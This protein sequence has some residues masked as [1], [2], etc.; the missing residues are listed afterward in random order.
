MIQQ[1]ALTQK[2]PQCL[3]CATI[4]PDHSTPSIAYFCMEYCVSPDL[5]VYSGGLGVLAGDQLKAANDLG[6]PLVGVG[7]FYHHGYFRQ[8]IGE[9]GWQIEEYPI[10]NPEAANLQILTDQEGQSVS[11]EV[12]IEDRTVKTQAYLKQIGTIPLIL[13]TT[14]IEENSSE[15]RMITAHLYGAKDEHD[16][17]TRIR[18]EMILGI[19]GK[20]MLDKLG[21]KVGVYHMNEG[22]SAFLTIAR[23]EELTE[24]DI[25]ADQA[26]EKIQANQ[27]FTNH[28]LVAAGNDIFPVSILEK[29]LSQYLPR[30]NGGFNALKDRANHLQDQPPGSWS[31]AKFAMATAK[32]TTAVSKIHSE[33]AAINW[34]KDKVEYVTNGVHHSWMDDEI[35]T[36]IDPDQDRFIRNHTDPDYLRRRMEQIDPEDFRSIRNK[37]R[38]EL[39]Q[40]ANEY[41]EKAYFDPDILTVGYA[42]RAAT[43]KRLYLL[44]TDPD[45]LLSIIEDTQQ[46]VQ[47]ILAAKAHPHDE[48][49]KKTIQ[50]LVHL[51]RDPRFRQHTLFIPDYNSR[52]AKH[53]VVGSDTWPNTPKKYEEAS[54][55]SG[56]KNGING[57]RQWS[58]DDGW[59]NEVPENFYF[60]IEDDK[61]PAVVADRMYVMLKERIAGEFYNGN[62][63]LSKTW[64][65]AA[66]QSMEYTISHF[67]AARMVRE[68]N[69]RFYQPLAKTT[70]IA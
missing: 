46:P 42:R 50:R 28:T 34:G 9:D 62:Y 7:I 53:L 8:K 57:G 13:M 33:A 66:L 54:G 60:Q 6:L 3:P 18:Q 15:D 59:M 4:T 23:F 25:P 52:I 27:L 65:Q 51:T 11:V 26:L 58:I 67:T 20:K 10:V 49:G 43:Y 1:E 38:R 36:L 17:Q 19:G 70:V 30:L 31:Q 61:N 40:F 47:I 29:E 39:T 35:K 32:E 24:Q 37:K 63:P 69:D 48:K 41:T 5:P 14:N 16:K 21:F 56:M 22:H 68:Y 45:R 12:P 64:V 55:T 2:N 44:F